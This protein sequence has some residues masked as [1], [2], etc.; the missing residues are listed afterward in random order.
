MITAL[1][2]VTAAVAGYARRLHQAVGECHHVASPLG[3]WLLLALCGPASSGAARAELGEVLGLDVQQAAAV[4]GRLLSAPH[5]LVAAA[6]GVWR[7]DDVRAEALSRWLASLPAVETGV[8]TD[9]AALDDWARRNTLGL[10]DR[11]PVELTD[12][13]LL[14][15]GTALATKIS[16]A[17]PFDVAPASA[18][19]LHSPWAGTLSRVLRTPEPDWGHGH[20]QFI[21]A[22]DQLGDVAVHT[23]QARD[24]LQVTSVAARPGVPAAE[25]LA[26]AC[27]LASA[28]ATFRPVARR[29]L[30]DLPLGAAPLWKITEQRVQ[31]TSPDGRAEYC[32]AVLPAWSADSTHD[33]SGHPGLGFGAAAAALAA[34]AGLDE[35]VCE[36]RQA[37][38][39]RYSRTGFEAAAVTGLG[40]GMGGS[41]RTRRGVMRTAELRFGQPY[42]VVA[43]TT[44]PDRRGGLPVTSPWWG[45][46]VFS[47]WITQ[48]EDADDPATDRI[49][50]ISRVARGAWNSLATRTDRPVP[51]A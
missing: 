50:R 11:F 6:A 24:G 7:R 34:L 21:A 45:L 38:V 48:P 19:G 2:D 46:P 31:T 8:L 29:S 9:Q 25:V 43:V 36:A 20:T 30:F 42:A 10:I 5:P 4:A 22:D 44:D 28:I 51:R 41:P 32:T 14:M 49:R 23:A 35:F 17:E 16:W 26:A 33:L 12:E 3:A 15:L 18:L 40:V 27:R 37:V 13:T 47:A 1:T 39:A